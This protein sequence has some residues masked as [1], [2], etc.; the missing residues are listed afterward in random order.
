VKMCWCGGDLKT[1][2]HPEYGECKVCGTL[3]A[4]NQPDDLK[5]QYGFVSYWHENMLNVGQPAIEQRSKDDF[6]NRISHWYNLIRSFQPTSSSIFEVGCAHGGFL[7]YCLEHGF[8]HAHGCE[9]D[10]ETC[11]FARKKFNLPVVIPGLFPHVSKVDA[12]AKYDAICGFDVIEHFEYPMAALNTMREMMHEGSYLYLQSPWYRGE[13]EKWPQF[14]FKEH[15]FMFNEK[16]LAAILSVSGLKLVKFQP[17][18]FA[19]DWE[20]VAKCA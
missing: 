13:G 20:A 16:S 9:V 2:P 1:G 3:V 15:L 11:E 14:N 8:Q 7:H 10:P 4:L 19:Y 5:K 6:K 12:L 18:I 17:G